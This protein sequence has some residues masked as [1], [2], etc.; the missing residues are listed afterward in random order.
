MR[1]SIKTLIVIIAI[2]T[3]AKAFEEPI[4]IGRLCMCFLGPCPCE[5]KA[6]GNFCR[7]FPDN[8]TLTLFDSK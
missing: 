2:I 7:Y 1:I 5:C 4:D 6:D 8:E 3:I